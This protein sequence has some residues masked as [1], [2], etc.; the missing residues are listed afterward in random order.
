MSLTGMIRKKA[1]LLLYDRCP[2]FAGSFPYFNS[3]VFFPKGD[4]TFKEACRQGIYERDTL[5]ALQAFAKPD[6]TVFDVGANIGLISASVL[7]TCRMCSVV[8]FEPSP[9]LLPFLRKTVGSSRHSDRWKMIESALSDHEG[10]ACFSAPPVEFSAFGGL[11]DT[12]RISG[13]HTVEVSLRTL[14]SVWDELGRPK[15]SVVKCDTEG[16]ELPVLVGARACIS[17]CRPAIV[18]EWNRLNLAA[19]KC[20]PSALVNWANT[21]DYD[22]F[23]LVGGIPVEGVNGLTVMLSVLN[24]E[25]FIL[26]PR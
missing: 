11:T 15:V 25:N 12:K 21:N 6:T 10:K 24:H 13:A 16:H 9:T 14:D 18:L 8:S 26:L 1:K 3:K 4:Y 22:I 20:D 2:G 7:E 17:T 5:Y 23:T 19:A